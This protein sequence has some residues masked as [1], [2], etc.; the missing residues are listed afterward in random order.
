MLGLEDKHRSGDRKI[1][2]PNLNSLQIQILDRSR[3][4][5]LSAWVFILEHLDTFKDRF[6]HSY[7]IVKVMFLE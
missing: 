6:D 7:A 1:N 4:Y 3:P 5:S 2:R